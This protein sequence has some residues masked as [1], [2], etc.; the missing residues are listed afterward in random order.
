MIFVGIVIMQPALILAI[1]IV[2]AWRRR[3]KS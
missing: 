1:G 2:V 3:Q